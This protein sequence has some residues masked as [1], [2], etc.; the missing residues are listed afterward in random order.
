MSAT[1]Q[2][3]AYGRMVNC[4]SQEIRCNVEYNGEICYQ[5]GSIHTARRSKHAAVYL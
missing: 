5:L 4:T 3:K 2:C 1:G